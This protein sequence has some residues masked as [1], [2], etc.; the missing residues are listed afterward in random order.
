VLHLWHPESERSKL[1]D[2]QAKLDRILQS[3]RLRAEQGLSALD[4]EAAQAA[5]G[6]R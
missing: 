1:S 3:D 2:N 4:V 6:V 5:L